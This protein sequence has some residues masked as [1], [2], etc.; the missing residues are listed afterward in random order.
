MRTNRYFIKFN[1]QNNRFEIHDSLRQSVVL[2]YMGAS[3]AHMKLKQL[4]GE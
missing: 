4:T 2:W 3:I 1:K